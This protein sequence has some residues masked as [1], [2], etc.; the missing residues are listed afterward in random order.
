MNAGLFVLAMLG[1]PADAEAAAPAA[2][3]A[4]V[5]G[6]TADEVARLLEVGEHE[7]AVERLDEV[8]PSA[9]YPPLVY[10]RG[11]VE[12]DRGNCP[13][14][15][16]HYE[17]YMA[18]DVLE[19]DAA[20]AARR[21]DR[22]KRLLEAARAHAVPIPPTPPST[23]PPPLQDEPPP[24]YADPWA[25]S[26]SAL[27]VLGLGVGAGLFAQGRAHERAAEDAFDLQTYRER[28]ARAESLQRTGVTV[29]AV[30]GGVLAIGVAR[31]VW[32]SVA[33][34]RAAD[35]AFHPLRVRF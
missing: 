12:E 18:M 7:R 9:Q 26:V 33:R 11:V 30:G 19:V 10:M 24:R 5:I 16:D 35:Q 15:I 8:D 25:I 29:L 2:P 34:K 28:G 3:T 31:F 23:P 4:E 21:R 1:P 17:Q 6:R 13:A 14:A 22:C 27:G 20:A 32:I